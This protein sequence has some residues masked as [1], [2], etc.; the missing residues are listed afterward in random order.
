[1]C[2]PC[3][4]RRQGRTTHLFLP[5]HLLLS[6]PLFFFPLFSLSLPMDRHYKIGK[7]MASIHLCSG[8]PWGERE[9]TKEKKKVMNWKWRHA[10]KPPKIMSRQKGV[11]PRQKSALRLPNPFEERLPKSHIACLILSIIFSQKAGALRA[12]T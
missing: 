2:V 8:G 12:K 9:K 6:I 3:R 4:R 11:V 5:H 7:T 1:M 10:T